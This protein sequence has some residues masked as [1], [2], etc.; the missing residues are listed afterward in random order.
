MFALK[1]NID[2][3]NIADFSSIELKIIYLYHP[4]YIIPQPTNP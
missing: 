3:S 4:K 2:T 1:I